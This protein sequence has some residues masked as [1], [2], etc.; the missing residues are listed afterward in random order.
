[1]NLTREFLTLDLIPPRVV[2]TRVSRL[3]QINYRRVVL[4][5][6]FVTMLIPAY[7]EAF[8][9][10]LSPLR[11]FLLAVCV[12]FGLHTLLGRAG[13][14]TGADMLVLGYGA[15]VTIALTVVHGSS[16]IPFAGITVIEAFGAYFAG[17]V[18]IRSAQEYSYVI[19]LMTGSLIVLAPFAI[20]ETLTGTL[21]IPEIINKIMTSNIREGSAYGRLGL[22]RVYAVFE[23]PILFG[24]YA[25][26]VIA[27]LATIYKSRP[28]LAACALSLA[29]FMTFLSLSS[30]P[31]L[32]CMIQVILLAWARVTGGKWVLLTC[33]LIFL[34]VTVD[35]LSDRTPVTILI[36]RLTFNP[37]SG[38]TRIAIFDAGIAA[39]FAHPVFG[40][41]FNDWT[42]PSWLTASVD[43]FWLLNTMR[44]GF[45]GGGLLV[46]C[47][48]LHVIAC[49]RATIP[50]P[51]DASL[52]QAYLI[53]LLAICFTLCTVHVWGSIGVFVM[54]FLGAGAWFYTPEKPE[55]E[56]QRPPAKLPFSRF[57]E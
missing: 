27:S 22:E 34:Y 9:L 25:A 3:G 13:R 14:V 4:T 26:S 32:A 39:A 37:L 54:F 57:N 46:A 6:L 50:D 49:L 29:F 41:G 19:K 47:F 15:W 23:H 24:L 53:T 45:V 40:I 21:I 7:Q 52:R 12:P 33:G 20:A 18:L 56:T 35:L 31:L 10:R 16:Q 44:Y 43:N 38:W 48:S 5:A 30:A 55:E 17:R 11:L 36:E 2:S 51:K 8:G 28:L 1:M 42:R